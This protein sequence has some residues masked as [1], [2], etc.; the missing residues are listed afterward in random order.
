MDKAALADVHLAVRRIFF[1][2][3]ILPM[4]SAHSFIHHQR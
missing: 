1:V 4:F 3:I 2:G